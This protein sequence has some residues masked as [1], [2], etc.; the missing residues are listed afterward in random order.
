VS[1]RNLAAVVLRA[2][3][4]T[5]DVTRAGGPGTYVDGEFAPASGPTTVQVRASVQPLTG[6]EL[7]R[8]PEGLRSRE[9]L[10]VYTVD[11][12]RCRAP[13]QAPDIISIDGFTWQVE[14]VERFDALGNYFHSVVS[15]E[16]S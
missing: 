14:K 15:K 16:P 9:L 12:L 1:L 3:T 5:Y 10:S 4:G 2:A 13:N 8:L 7:M 11:E 6:V